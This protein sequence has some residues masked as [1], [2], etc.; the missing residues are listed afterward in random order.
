MQSI[1]DLA[2]SPD[3]PLV[4]ASASDDTTIRIWSLAKTH[5]KQP[6]LAIL[7]GEGHSWDIL[8]VV[9]GGLQLLTTSSYAHNHLV[10]PPDGPLCALGRTRPGY[11]PCKSFRVDNP[12]IV[13]RE[14]TDA[15]SLSGRFQILPRSI[16]IPRSWFIIRIFLRRKCTV[17]W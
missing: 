16:Q 4:L 13:G 6:C 8:T 14:R 7:G 15:G 11:Q 10:I 17:V 9:R 12:R 5:F 1:N 2:T 3:N